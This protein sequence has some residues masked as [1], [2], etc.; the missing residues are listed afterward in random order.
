MKD[1]IYQ[2]A[3]R[4]KLVPVSGESNTYDF[5]RVKGTVTQEG[6]PLAANTLM[7]EAVSKKLFLNDDDHTVSEALNHIVCPEVA[8]AT[9]AADGSAMTATCG[10]TTVTG[11]VTRQT[12]CWRTIALQRLPQ[13]RISDSQKVCGKLVTQR[14]L[15][16]VG[17]SAHA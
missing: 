10:D 6:T 1:A 5:E 7:Q 4:W 15:K 16:S 3:N 13:W 2:H 11:S 12:A 9:N 17:S 8:I 14:S